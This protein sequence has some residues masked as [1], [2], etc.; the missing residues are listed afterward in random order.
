MSPENS[1]LG[2]QNN[3]LRL[4]LDLRLIIVVLLAIIV[5]MAVVWKPWISTGA[6][7][8]TVQ[9]T[10]E[11]TIT[12]APD[13]YVFYPNYPFKNAD[14]DAALAELTKKSDEVVAQLK[15][16]GVA[17]NKIKTDSSGY[18]FPVYYE[19]TDKEAT[20]TLQLTVTV[21]NH[22]LAQKVQDYLITTTPSGAVSPQANFSDSKRKELEN[23]ARDEATK[24]ARAKADQS[25]KNLG[26]KVGKVKSLSDGSGFGGIIPLGVEPSLSV[27]KDTASSRELSIQPGEN[28]LNYSV[29]V[30]Y[31]IR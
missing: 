25:A 18:D 3:K 14:K 7:D 11:A 22:E 4:T 9:V 21:D 10:G 6:D 2:R 30:V 12:A 26:F 23:K 31:F 27:A 16:L 13:E 29:T 15:T 28:D 8:R 19:T 5:G 17:D 24:D 20:Y 1:P